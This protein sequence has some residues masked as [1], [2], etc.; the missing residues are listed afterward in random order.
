MIVDM[1]NVFINAPDKKGETAMDL[2][3]KNGHKE[4]VAL[5]QSK[6]RTNEEIRKQKNR[7]DNIL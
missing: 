6:G 5:L 1:P 3:L 7:W 4:I 2:A